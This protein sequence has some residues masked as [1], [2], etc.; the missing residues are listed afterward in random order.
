MHCNFICSLSDVI[1]KT[2]SQSVTLRSQRVVNHSQLL[3]AAMRADNKPVF[4]LVCD[5]ARSCCRAPCCSPVLPQQTRHTPRL[6]SNGGTDRQTDRRTD[7]RTDARLFHRPIISS[8]SRPREYIRG[9]LCRRPLVLQRVR[10]RQTADC[11]HPPTR[12]T[13]NDQTL[14]TR[15][16][17]RWLLANC[18]TSHSPA[19]TVIPE[20]RKI[21]RFS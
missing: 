6:L 15:Y 2:F 8:G 4:S 14:P 5:T 9:R 7:R 13:C 11:T 20:E 3:P 1:I 19:L 17:C 12:G 16:Y 18:I 10:D 21:D